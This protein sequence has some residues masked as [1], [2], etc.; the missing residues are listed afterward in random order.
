MRR[1]RFNWPLP[2]ALTSAILLS[3]ILTACNPAQLLCR[4]AGCTSSSQPPDAAG[5]F[6][7]YSDVAPDVRPRLTVSLN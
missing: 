4:I 6:S 2:L 3:S 1:A 5:T 7:Y